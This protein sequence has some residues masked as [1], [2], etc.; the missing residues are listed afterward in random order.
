MQRR[1]EPM[2]PAS[3]VVFCVVFSQSTQTFA[4]TTGG[5]IMAKI[6]YE[7]GDRFEYPHSRKGFNNYGIV[8][9][10]TEAV[11]FEVGSRSGPVLSKGPIPSDAVP[12]PKGVK[13]SVSFAMDAICVALGVDVEA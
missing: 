7:V 8:V 6:T 11:L 13:F 10:T 4:K 9:S 2:N 3:E 1:T 12:S 5:F